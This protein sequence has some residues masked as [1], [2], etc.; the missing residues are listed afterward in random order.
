LNPEALPAYGF[1]HLEGQHTAIQALEGMIHSQRLPQGLLF[2]GMPGCGRLLAARTL[3]MMGNCQG[4]SPPCGVCRSC[5]KILEE[6]HPDFLKLAPVNGILRIEAVRGLTEKLMRRPYEAR[7]R[8]VLMEEAETLN[9]EAA[10]ALLK[11]L[12]EPPEATYFVLLSSQPHWLLETIRS[13]CQEV[14]F[15]PLSVEALA[16]RLLPLS[17][18][19]EA[20]LAAAKLA[21]GNLRQGERLAQE[22]HKRRLLARLLAGGFPLA[23]ATALLLAEWLSQDKAS[24]EITLD[25]LEGLFRDICLAAT[26][27]DVL[28]THGIS[29]DCREEL[30][31]AGK[32]ISAQQ[33]LDIVYRIREVRRRMGQNALPRLSL[34]VLLLGLQ[35]KGSGFPLG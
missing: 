28:C 8:F 19:A 16:A 5:R 15:T 14:R 12:E 1:W 18:D 33:A 10:N 26:E 30:L 9:R 34:D 21:F 20:A 22:S 2:S 25:I 32:K 24:A 4:E 11:V 6:K 27:A 17:P 35:P 31:N 13:R 29:L 7:M 23:A 3:M